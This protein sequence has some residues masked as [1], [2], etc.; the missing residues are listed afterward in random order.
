MSSAGKNSALITAKN[1][2]ICYGDS[3]VIQDASF[4]IYSSD[5]VCLVGANGSGKST[6]M[7]AMLGLKALTSGKIIFHRSIKSG[8]SIGYFPQEAKIERNFPATAEEIVLS[9]RLG[10]MKRRCFYSMKDKEAARHNM[11]LMGI[12]DYARKSFAELSGGQKQKVLLARALTATNSMLMLDEPSNNL[13]Y[14]SRRE[15]YE[16]LKKLNKEMGVTIVMITHDLD[17]EDLIG[18]KV[19]A[20]NAGET[21]MLETK[22][23]LEKYK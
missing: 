10:Q 22:M 17:T 3:K 2:S 14:E 4:E 6:L 19:L 21:T 8:S 9:G 1:V 20:I 5:F 12:L 13:D 15:F 7:K 11:E 16:I 23:F 18:N